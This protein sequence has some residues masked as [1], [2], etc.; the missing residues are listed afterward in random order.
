MIFVIVKAFIKALSV[1]ETSTVEVVKDKDDKEP[2]EGTV[3][4]GDS[5]FRFKYLNAS[6][7]EFREK[8]DKDKYKMEQVKKLN[9]FELGVSE[10]ISTEEFIKREMMLTLV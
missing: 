4:T 7:K 6:L 1:K 3:G 2:D 9:F 5:V 10:E 8:A